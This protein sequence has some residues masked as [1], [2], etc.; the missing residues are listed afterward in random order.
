MIDT[1]V[2][3]LRFPSIFKSPKKFFRLQYFRIRLHLRDLLTLVAMKWSSPRGKRW[4]NR[5]LQLDRSKVAPAAV[6]LHQNMYSAFADGNVAKL[7]TLCTDGIYDSFRARIGTRQPSEKVKWELLK[8]NQTKVVSDR[9]AKLPMG[10]QALRQAVVRI[11]S[12]Q[13]LTR[14]VRGVKVN[15]TGAEKDVVEY[16][17][18][19]STI[20]GWQPGSWKIWGTT[21][22]T[23]LKD[24]DHW[25]RLAKR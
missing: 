1:F 4:Y 10:D 20:R 25:Q 15:G 2:T 12:Q 18:V 3:P 24:C 11:S 16:V 9:I 6:E 14:F 17:V 23:T 8:Y 19:Q 5:V 21:K 22:E 13:R 7:K